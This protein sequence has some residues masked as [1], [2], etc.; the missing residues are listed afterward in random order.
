MLVRAAAALLAVVLAT[1]CVSAPPRP[2]GLPTTAGTPGLREFVPQEH[3]PTVT[4]LVN[5]GAVIL[6]K[7]NMHELA[8]GISA[9]T[10]H[11]SRRRRSA[12]AIPTTA[13][14]SPAAAA[15]APAPPSPRGWHPAG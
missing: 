4:S 3:A 9:T 1:G 2:A 12:R 8:F 11:S 15:A 6:G 5:A 10:R 14:V 13:R 7:T